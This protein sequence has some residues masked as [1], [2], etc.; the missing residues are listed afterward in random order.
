MLLLI[1]TLVGVVAVGISAYVLYQQYQ[2]QKRKYERKG[3]K[4]IR[5]I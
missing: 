3:K 4:W 2:E 5:N 1:N